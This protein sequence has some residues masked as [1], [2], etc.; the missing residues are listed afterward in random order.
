MKLIIQIPCFNEEAQLAATLRAL[1][2]SLPSIDSVEVLI[3]D[4]GSSDGTAQVAKESGAH[5]IIQLPQHLGLAA[6]F[7]AGLDACLLHGADIIVNT[8]ADNQYPADGIRQLIDP[9][10]AGRAEIAIG[11]RGTATLPHFSPAKRFLQRAGSWIVSQAAGI[12]IPDA[13]SG[14]R[15][16]TRDAALRTM[17]LSHFSYTLETLIQAAAK[18]IPVVFIPIKANPPTRPSRLVRSIPQYLFVST[19]TL[20]RAYAMYSPLKVFSLLGGIF[21]AAG[22]AL[23]ARFVYYFLVLNQG[24]GHIQSLILAAVLLIMGV[25]IGCLGLLADLIAANRKIL[26]ET[27]YHVK[28]MEYASGAPT[29]SKK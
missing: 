5:H 7:S 1:P 21:F 3:V 19:A 14:F 18:G 6:A 16:Y 2:R 29:H 28:R 13:T 25:Q 22:L 8:D 10:L 20:L 9:L 17:L 4:D 15:A 23:G 26:E 11:D 27:Q 24:S 12:P